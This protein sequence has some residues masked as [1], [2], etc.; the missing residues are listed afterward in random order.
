[1]YPSC[2]QERSRSRGAFAVH[3]RAVKR[4]TRS[5]GQ[6]RCPPL[7][8]LPSFLPIPLFALKVLVQIH[9]PNL[10]GGKGK[11]RGPEGH[12]TER[13]VIH[14]HSHFIT[15]TGGV[16][17]QRERAVQFQGTSRQQTAEAKEQKT[18]D[19]TKLDSLHV[20]IVHGGTLKPLK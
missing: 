7:S 18:A 6:S 19:R 8:T 9:W 14:K 5:S 12:G 2:R 17:H 3:P 4:V 11:S 16:P 1:M 10:N 13:D 20:S 15:A